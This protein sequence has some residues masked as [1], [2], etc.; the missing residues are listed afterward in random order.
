M[1]IKK[2]NN[3]KYLSLTVG[4]EAQMQKQ[5]VV[6]PAAAVMAKVWWTYDQVH[7]G[8]CAAGQRYIYI[9]LKSSVEKGNCKK[10]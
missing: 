10:N 9:A 4:K 5:R 1:M 8:G 3:I 2:Y 6:A 7:F